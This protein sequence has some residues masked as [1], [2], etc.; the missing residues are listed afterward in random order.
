MLATDV[1][2][3]AIIREPPILIDR[4]VQSV[5]NGK[6]RIVVLQ[7]KSERLESLKWAALSEPLPYWL[8]LH[9]HLSRHQ[10]ITEVLEVLECPHNLLV[11]GDFD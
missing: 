9:Q 4:L 2:L 6:A 11:A 8:P 3:E 1:V 10:V 5:R 7:S